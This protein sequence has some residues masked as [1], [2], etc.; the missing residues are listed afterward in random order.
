MDTKDRE[1]RER[2]KKMQKGC[3]QTRFELKNGF[4]GAGKKAKKVA[5]AA[6]LEPATGWLTATL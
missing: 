4:S 3:R 5:P 1:R 6:G 2:A